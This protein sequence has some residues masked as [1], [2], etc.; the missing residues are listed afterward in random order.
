MSN[1]KLIFSVILFFV[2]IFVANIVADVT[3]K[4]T[5]STVISPD[6]YQISAKN[7]QQWSIYRTYNGI[8]QKIT[9]FNPESSEIDYTIWQNY[10]FYSNGI[11]QENLQY[12]VKNLDTGETNI[13][14]S[15]KNNNFNQAKPFSLYVVDQKVI[16]DKLYFSIGG[17]LSKSGLFVLNLPP[18]GKP[19][20]ISNI[21]GQITNMNNS[22]WIIDGIGNGCWGGASYYTLNTKTDQVKKIT[23]VEEL[24]DDSGTKF[25]GINKDS[26]FIVGSYKYDQTS[27]NKIN[28]IDIALIDINNPK[29]IQTINNLPSGIDNI[30]YLKENNNLILFN[31]ATAY[32]YDFL[33]QKFSEIFTYPNIWQNTDHITFDF[34]GDLF[35]FYN[36]TYNEGFSK[37]LLTNKLQN[38]QPKSEKLKTKKTPEDCFKEMNLP[39]EYRLVLE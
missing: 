32:L 17:Y 7:N 14:F 1:L 6:P 12:L 9:E 29:K 15:Q 11:Y 35:C 36:Y 21:G 16:N 10:Y 31:H 24:C 27:E 8:S 25:I 30:G 3:K 19:K 18:T 28:Y 22:F 37:D 5:A 13:I 39:S 33:S 2:S 4:T 23:S 34:D 26:Q 38:C 20:M